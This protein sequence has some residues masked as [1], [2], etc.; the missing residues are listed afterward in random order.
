MKAILYLF[1]GTG[2]TR[3]CGDYLAK[4]LKEQG[5]ETDVYEYRSG[6]SDIPNPNDYDLVGIG[7]PIHAFNVPEAF[8]KFIK[9]LP[10][11]ENKNYFIFKVSGEPF[12]PNNSS[13]YHIYRILKK[14]GYH[15]IMEKHFLMP[16]N[17][18]FKYKDE[19]QKQMY[20]YLDPL[21]NVMAIRL[22]KGEV[23]KIE[24]NPVHTVWSFFLRIEW[25][26]PKVNAAFLH[27]DKKTCTNCMLCVNNCPTK[28]L[29]VTDKRKIKT[30][31]QCAL[32]MRCSLNCPT[33]A[34][35]MGIFQ[36]WAVRG[37]FHYKQLANDKNNPGTYVNY[38][39]KGYFKLF[40]KYFLKQNELLRKYGLEIP[41]QY[42][43]ENKLE[44]LKK[45]KSKN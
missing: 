28:S 7:Y 36:P 15:L 35:H 4:H 38:K 42:T 34:L 44:N 26:A 6:D 39:T 37:G 8:V 30:T 45:N 9:A 5:I 1:T 10:K 3:L 13:S 31:S 12:P 40:R 25:I 41:V 19:L 21:A 14:K 16:Y 32:C 22:A 2:N 33:N 20:L 17:I 43:E 29:Y 23:D 18:M 11:V 27:N 24:Y